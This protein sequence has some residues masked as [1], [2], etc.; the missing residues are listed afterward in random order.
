MVNLKQTK[1]PRPVNK[2]SDDALKIRTDIKSP[3]KLRPLVSPGPL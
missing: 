1:K 2:S 3:I